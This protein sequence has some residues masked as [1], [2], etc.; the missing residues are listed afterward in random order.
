[1]RSIVGRLLEHSRVYYFHNDGNPEIYCA[2]ADWMERNFFRRIEVCFP[3]RRNQHRDR[4]VEDLETYLADNTQ[5]WVLGADGGYTR[6]VADNAPAV[7]AQETLLRRTRTRMTRRYPAQLTR[8]RKLPPFRYSI[9][10]S[11]SVAVNGCRV[12][13]ALRKHDLERATLRVQLDFGSAVAL[14]PRCSSTARRS[15]TIRD[16]ASRCHGGVRSSNGSTLSLRRCAPTSA[17]EHPLLFLRKS[18]HVR[19]LQ[20]IRAVLVIVRVRNIEAD[21]VQPRSPRQHELRERLVQLPLAGV[22]A[23][24]QRRGFDPLRLRRST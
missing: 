18:R 12:E 2:S 11:R 10:F 7:S 4:I 3:M 9:S 17:R 22:C 1:M 19:V 6:V 23:G 14:R 21:L 15:S 16:S 5:A 13:P 8:S 20:Q 24:N